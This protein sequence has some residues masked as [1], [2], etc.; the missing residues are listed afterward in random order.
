M[1]KLFENE[2]E[3]KEGKPPVSEDG[4]VSKRPGSGKGILEGPVVRGKAL[5]TLFKEQQ[6]THGESKLFGVFTTED[7]E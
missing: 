3:F 1:K 5:W 7:I 2:L 6:E 4:K